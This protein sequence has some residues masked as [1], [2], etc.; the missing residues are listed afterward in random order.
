MQ[1]FR[2]LNWQVYKDAK[3]LF[4]YVY[5]IISKLPK[6]LRYELGGQIL[7]A[8]SSV[9]LNIAEGSGKSTDKELRRYFDI[10]LGSLYE[11]VAGADILV[12]NGLIQKDQFA[13][14]LKKSENIAKQLGGFRKTLS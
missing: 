6:E 8:G 9:I 10:S 5:D 3:E 13:V 14:V 12:D 1:P 4:R 7:R 2:F 11:L